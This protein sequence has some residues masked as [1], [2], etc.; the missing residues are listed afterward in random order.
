MKFINAYQHKVSEVYIK[1]TPE[2]T[3]KKRELQKLV[4]CLSENYKPVLIGIRPK[5]WGLLFFA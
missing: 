4:N 2:Y 3:E 1:S 5:G